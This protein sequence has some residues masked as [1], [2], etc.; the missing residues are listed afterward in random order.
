MS[1]PV[2]STPETKITGSNGFPAKG[3]LPEPR[4]LTG[5]FDSSG[6]IVTGNNTTLTG[7]FSSSGK[8]VTGSGTAFT[9]E[10]SPGDR[11]YSTNDKQYRVVDVINSDTELILQNPFTNDQSGENVVI[12]TRFADE[13]VSEYGVWLFSTT[14]NEIR[15]ITSVE[16][17]YLYLESGFSSDVTGDA[18]KI[19]IP[20]FSYIGALSS[21]S[22]AA[23][24]QQ[25]TFPVDQSRNV[26]QQYGTLTPV[27][28]DA[29][30]SG[31]EITFHVKF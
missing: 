30:G 25:E 23:T 3:T 24:Y 6:K 8:T 9:S 18:V 5:T 20:K 7:T 2:V 17:D 13:I 26:E 10:L 11:L 1:Q 15:R 12:G 14:N 31:Q 16:N 27:T 28:Y 22:S 4:T 19:T 21:G 29:S